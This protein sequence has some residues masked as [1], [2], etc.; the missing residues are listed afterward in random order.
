[1]IP[2]RF[3]AKKFPLS[4]FLSA[5]ASWAAWRAL[6]RDGAMTHTTT[7]DTAPAPC[8]TPIGRLGADLAARSKGRE[9]RAAMARFARA[10]I[11]I[12][13]VHSP[14][15][16]ALWCHDHRGGSSG[17]VGA[18]VRLAPGDETAMV[19]VLVAL[20]PALRRAAAYLVRHGTE[21]DGAETEVL[22]IAWERV[23]AVASSG[24]SRHA[25]SAVVDGVWDRARILVHRA[26]RRRS[27]EPMLAEH[28]DPE[29]LDADPAVRVSTVLLDAERA[30]VLTGRQARLL[31]DT[32]V[33]DR[34]VAELAAAAGRD[35]RAVRQER[36]R[37]EL[38]LG[39]HLARST[40]VAEPSPYTGS[41]S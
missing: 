24:P 31:H 20:R 4:R 35:P 3:P 30:R 16:L 33:L 6:G 5:L 23:L 38:V 29:A 34:P 12:P 9:A 27:R 25:A 39:R 10:G 37:A 2:A 28:V 21:R 32:R 40:R 19:C 17:V 26:A 7:T 15:E 18:L 11:E 14:L 8:T 13:D 41:G 36:R 22:G 1:M